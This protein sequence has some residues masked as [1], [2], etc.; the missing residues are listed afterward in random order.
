M[1]VAV[2]VEVLALGGVMMPVAIIG[3]VPVRVPKVVER[4][5][6]GRE[7]DDDTVEKREAGPVALKG[8][9]PDVVRG[10][11]ADDCANTAW[12]EPPCERGL[13]GYEWLLDWYDGTGGG[14]GIS[15][16]GMSDENDC[17]SAD[18]VDPDVVAVVV[19]AGGEEV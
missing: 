10:V 4:G 3:G 2:E 16:A 14:G 13:L 11:S 8:E 6:C 15:M 7:V 18:V 19:V 9:G 12:N 17:G 5:M 1:A